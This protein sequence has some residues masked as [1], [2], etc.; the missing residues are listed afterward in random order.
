MNIRAF[1]A[2]A[3]ALA[4]AGA[5]SA[6]VGGRTVVVRAAPNASLGKPVLVTSSGLTLYH[7]AGE[8]PGAIK[9]SGACARLWPPLLVPAGAKVK[10]G[11]GLGAG[12]LGTTRRA[13]GKRQVVYSGMPLYRYAGDRRAGDARGQGIGGVWSAVTPVA[14]PAAAPPPSPPDNTRGHR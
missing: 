9:C 7:M 4:V 13:G 1:L 10:A 5:A 8:T 11:A 2:S 12:T 6:A 14:A 3:L